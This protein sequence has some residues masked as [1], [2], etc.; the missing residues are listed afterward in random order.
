MKDPRSEISFTGYKHVKQLNRCHLNKVASSASEKLHNAWNELKLPTDEGYLLADSFN[1]AIIRDPLSRLYSGY[2]NKCKH[3]IEREKR[4]CPNFLQARRKP[5]SFLLWLQSQEKDNKTFHRNLHFRSM[6][7][8]CKIDNNHIVL[9]LES[10][11]VNMH[12]SRLWRALGV[13]HEEVDK[14]YPPMKGK[15]DFWYYA[16]AANETHEYYNCETLDLALPLLRND[17]EGPYQD[18]FPL[19]AW[20]IEM[21]KKC[22]LAES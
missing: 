6:S 9:H 8:Q 16:N 21:R 22:S 19:P 13:P 11:N 15:K 7:E 17:Y 2:W 3:Q 18:F 5:P 12:L 1:F 4:Q 14:Q 10:P 20:A